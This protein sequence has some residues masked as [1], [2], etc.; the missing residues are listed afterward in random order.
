MTVILGIDPGSRVTGYGVVRS[1]PQRT[2]FLTCGCIRLATDGSFDERLVQLY[3]ELA[4]V[5]AEHRPTE[6]AIERVF[7]NRNADSALKLGHARGVAML[8]ARRAGLVVSEYTATQIKQSVVGRGHAEKVQVQH[9]VRFLLGL[10]AEPSTDAADA[11]AAA[12]CH[13]AMRDGRA[14]LANAGWRQ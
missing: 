6:A 4:A 11:L 2:E 1:A 10:S 13:A 12:L 5:I 14:R 9:M 3:D 8:A 7:M